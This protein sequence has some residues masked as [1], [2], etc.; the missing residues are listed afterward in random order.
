MPGPDYA[1]TRIHRSRTSLQGLQMSGCLLPACCCTARL[2]LGVAQHCPLNACCSLCFRD[3]SGQEEWQRPV[4]RSGSSARTEGGSH[5]LLL[6]HAIMGYSPI[7]HGQR[8]RRSHLC[9]A[10]PRR[11]P[12]RQAD[13]CGAQVVDH[14]WITAHRV[15]AQRFWCAAARTSGV[16]IAYTNPRSTRPSSNQGG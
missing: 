2:S 8:S 15:G 13:C 10:A 11:H 12:R 5:M 1:R 4:P 16:S 7:G 9:L 6:V 3:L 14:H